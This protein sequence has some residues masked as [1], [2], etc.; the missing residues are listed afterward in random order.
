[1][2]RL[3]EDDPLSHAIFRLL[4]FSALWA[5]GIADLTFLGQLPPQRRNHSDQF[6]R[7][8]ITGKCYTKLTD[9]VTIKQFI[10]E[11]QFPSHIQM[12]RS[13]YV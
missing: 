7:N 3:L 4:M 13:Y 11:A 1:M 6:I 9:E 8:I 12:I 2:K 10:P 5:I